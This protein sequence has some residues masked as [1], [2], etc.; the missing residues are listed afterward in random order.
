[1]PNYENSKIYCIR[2]Y[3]CEEIYIGS[4]IQNLSSRM[5]KHRSAYKKN[6]ST[7]TATKIL[8]YDDCYIE[9]LEYYPCKNRMELNR[10]E[11][12]YIRNNNCVNKIIA[13][14]TIQEYRLENKVAISNQKKFNITCNCG[15]TIRKYSIYNHRISK[16]HLN[17]MSMSN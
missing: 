6:R 5:S 1:M 10:K 4:T 8:Q 14:R 7:T 17:Y 16:K 3:Q 2:S 13:G 9:L 15:S 12:Q 11:G